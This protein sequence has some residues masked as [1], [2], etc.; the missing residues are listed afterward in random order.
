[1]L[2]RLLR[3]KLLLLS[4][5]PLPVTKTHLLF[6]QCAAVKICFENHLAVTYYMRQAAAGEHFSTKVLTRCSVFS[7]NCGFL[8]RFVGQ[9]NGLC[10]DF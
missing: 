6:L 4:N 7:W 3:T 9:M 5:N 1:V 2:R 8:L 10:F